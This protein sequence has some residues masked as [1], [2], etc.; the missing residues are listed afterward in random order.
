MKSTGNGCGIQID[1]FSAQTEPY[2]SNFNDVYD[3]GVFVGVFSFLTHPPGGPV[4][5]CECP[6]P[7]W[8]GSRNSSTLDI[9]NPVCNGSIWLLSITFLSFSFYRSDPKPFRSANLAGNRNKIDTALWS[10]PSAIPKRGWR[11]LAAA[12]FY[13]H[14]GFK[15]N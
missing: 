10:R 15:S 8:S 9:Q 5:T 14:V 11:A 4:T 1:G 13:V 3:M 7:D 6:Q 2:G 12:P